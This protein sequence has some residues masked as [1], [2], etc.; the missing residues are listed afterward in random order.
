MTR[1]RSPTN[2]W[3]S[4]DKLKGMDVPVSG[5]LGPSQVVDTCL[6]HVAVGRDR[7]EKEVGMGTENIHAK[8]LVTKIQ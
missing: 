5:I 8:R 6:S 4:Q 1:P 3:Q 7:A 2:W